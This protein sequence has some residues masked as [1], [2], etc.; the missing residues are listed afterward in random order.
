MDTGALTS[1]LRCWLE[2]QPPPPASDETALLTA[3][4]HHRLAGT[5][6][7]I[8]T[9]LR[10]SNATQARAAWADNLGA[11]LL[12]VETLHR[13]W[14][15][16][17]PPPLVFKGADVA[18]N[19]LDDP[20]A[21]QA[22]DLDLLVPPAAWPEL[23][24]HL[25]RAADAVEHPRHAHLAGDP[26]LA[27]GLRFGPVL[28]ELHAHPW[29]PHRG[30]PDGWF[31]SARGRPGRLG[32][33]DVIYPRPED[34]LLL[35]LG[36]QAKGAFTTDL[37]DWLDLALILKTCGPGPAT[38]AART[39]L[40]RPWQV[41]RRRL[42]RVGLASPLPGGPAARAIDA[43]LPDPTAARSEPRAAHLIKALLAPAEAWPGLAM[44]LAVARRGGP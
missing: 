36:N 7:H 20:G 28:I 8:G 12:R 30:G 5:L 35:W 34:R 44:R 42:G 2:G 11:H 19:L 43:L 16:R 4:R 25:G 10:E 21:R 39:G 38:L 23:A 29:P 14:P 33:T 15:T 17:A 13:I 9:P 37:A 40:E 27:V 32:D 18:E 3:A 26:P 22:R 31:F 41:A 24:R 6:Y 1:L